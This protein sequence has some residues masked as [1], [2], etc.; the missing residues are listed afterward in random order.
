MRRKRQSS[1]LSA[2]TIIGAAALCSKALGVIRDRLF[3]S[4]FG[5]G[6][7]LDIY[8]VAFRLPDLL[9]NI[10][11]SGVIS[12]AFI[13]VLARY[14]SK[15]QI[16]QAW[17]LSNSLLNLLAILLFILII[18]FYIIAPYLMPLFA[19][20]FDDLKME[21]TIQLTRIMLLTPIF[22]T[23]SNI[24]SGILNTFKKFFIYALTP[25]AYN[26]GI[27]FGTIFL[28]PH[29]GIHGVA[30][31]VVIGSILH[32][33]IQIPS[34]ISTGFRYQPI[35]VISEELKRVGRLMGPRI[36]GLA[37]HQINII[38]NL[39]IASTLVIGSV[40]I[41]NFAFNLQS[42]PLGIFGISFAI[43]AFPILSH[44]ASES[45]QSVF[46]QTF[47]QTFR[48]ILFFVIPS[49][50]LI[51]LLRAQ[52][53]RVVLG[54]GAFDWE[55]TI[56]TA[57]MLGFFSL[58]LFAQCLIPLIARSFYALEETRTPVIVSVF[59]MA[60]NIALSLFLV[61]SHGVIGLAMAFSI[62]SFVNMLTL[63]VLL[64]VRFHGLDDRRIIT[65]IVKTTIASLVMGVYAYGTLYA[66]APLVN[67]RTFVGIATQGLVAG[68]IGIIVFLLMSHVLRNDE[69]NVFQKIMRTKLRLQ[70]GFV[71]LIRNG[72][73][74]E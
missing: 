74:H 70:Q 8:F 30:A 43:A 65:S 4:M 20:G 27:I 71:P 63:L 31:G 69:V 54:T 28:A 60:L 58:S 9:H 66:V 45:D 14:V 34:V 42:L 73:N 25:I 41:F 59:S 24:F 10:L 61:K 11:I 51:L 33:A 48:R 49:S 72:D 68:T 47:S 12:A 23:L 7:E 37:A 5:A 15:K 18:V 26:L 57:R 44:Q 46:V 62:A 39:S 22:F 1:I 55:D 50:I 67:M 40:A 2:A 6:D 38:V 56:L 16:D 17:K 36:F 52:I 32:F 29:W 13:P 19:I 53:V 21:V 35:I 3:A 64:H